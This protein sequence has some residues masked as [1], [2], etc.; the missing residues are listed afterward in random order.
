VT[1]YLEGV[2]RAIRNGAATQVALFRRRDSKELGRLV[3][4][5]R[6]Y[7]RLRIRIPVRIRQGD[8]LNKRFELK[9]KPLGWDLAS[10][11]L[12]REYKGP[13]RHE[14]KMPIQSGKSRR[15]R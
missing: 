5:G 13:I 12:V 15:L 1:W 2:G 14:F 7:H 4:R 8:D 6:V 11:Y 3:F 9:L 10:L